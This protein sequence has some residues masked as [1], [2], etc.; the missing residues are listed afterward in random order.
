M[1][2]NQRR[3][4]ILKATHRESY[5]LLKTVANHAFESV[6][7]EAAKLRWKTRFGH[8]SEP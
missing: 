1:D 8:L 4:A 6:N 2:A 3:G 5:C 7:P